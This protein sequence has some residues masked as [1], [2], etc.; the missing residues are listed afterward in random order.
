M[1]VQFKNNIDLNGSQILNAAV[2][3]ATTATRPA[4]PVTGQMIFN[5]TLSSLEVY[6]GSA[7]EAV[8]GT[9]GFYDEIAA[10]TG[11]TVTN[12]T[13]GGTATV[14]H[15]D[16][17][18]V[19]NITATSRT[20]VDSLTFDDFGHVTGYTTATESVVD[21]DTTY[22]LGS[23][24]GTNTANITL[25]PSSGGS[26][27]VQI[28]GGSN[29]TVNESAGV[30]TIS[31]TTGSN[32]YAE[33]LGFDTATGILSVT[34]NGTTDLSQSLDGR[35]LQAE[36]DTL[37][38][39]TDRGAS[40]T[41]S[42]TVGG[43]VVNGDLTVSGAHTVTSAEEVLIED[44]T[45]L[46]NSNVTG[47][48]TEDAGIIIERGTSSNVGVVWDESADEFALIDTTDA[49]GTAGDIVIADYVDLRVGALKVDDTLAVGNIPASTVDTDK[50]LVNDAGTIKAR[51]GAQVRSDIGAGTMSSF[52]V[53]DGTTAGGLSDGSTL[54]VQG[55]GL[56]SVS[57][58]G[59]G[60]LTISTTANNYSLPSATTSV[61]GGV[62]L[63]TT[64]EAATGTDT[65]RA[66]TPAGLVSYSNSKRYK[67]SIGN[68]AD[69]SFAIHHGFGTK[70][71]IVQVYDNGTGDYTYA[72]VSHVDVNNVSVEFATAP[73]TNQYRVLV[74]E[75]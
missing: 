48:P 26:Q 39:V 18:T 33:A 45:L 70:D 60:R 73:T 21:T 38:S 10:G 22:T 6:N 62:E 58:D 25:T 42:I 46:L 55:T 72:G 44:S 69:T 50:F 51:T 37:D 35:Y 67:T 15:G 47:T 1:A 29:V 41:N 13:G 59:S 14:G 27:S 68:G 11:I 12:G 4:S 43:L 63:A 23:S 40:T 36:T 3:T 24:D 28:A 66:V 74:Y 57:H 65:E 30:I 2:E 17:S 52:N 9:S 75:L 5:T 56:I 71:V 16:T 7:W 61:V 31:S 32:F 20:Y 34:M 8:D 54:D 19:S 64:T 49:G 53:T